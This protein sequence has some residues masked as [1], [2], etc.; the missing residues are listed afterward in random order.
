MDLLV[1]KVLKKVLS[2]YIKSC[3]DLGSGNDIKLGTNSSVQLRN[4]QLKEQVIGKMM[5]LPKAIE[6]ESA[7]CNEMNVTVPLSLMKKPI[8]IEIEGVHASA[9]EVDTENKTK[10]VVIIKSTTKK[11]KRQIIDTILINVNNFIFEYQSKDLKII[12]SFESF[13]SYFADKNFKKISEIGTEVA[14]NNVFTLRRVVEIKNFNM[15]VIK[16]NKEFYLIRNMNIDGKITQIR[17]EDTYQ[18][19]ETNVSLNIN[20][21]R[22]VLLTEEYMITS[23]F[24]SHFI[25]IYTSSLLF[26][27]DGTK[28]K[29]YH[30]G[31]TIIS[32]RLG[33]FEITVKNEG[34]TEILRLV[35]EQFRSNISIE[36]SQNTHCINFSSGVGMVEMIYESNGVGKRVLSAFGDNV[37]NT[38]INVI[39]NEGILNK[40][41][42]KISLDG[43][44]ISF[45]SAVV[46]KLID[47]IKL[48]IIDKLNNSQQEK[49]I[50]QEPESTKNFIEVSKLIV[51][52]LRKHL[53]VIAQKC[54]LNSF[55][56]IV[57]RL[58]MTVQ[59]KN[60]I[61]SIPFEEGGGC[62]MYIEGIEFNNSPKFLNLTM[63][64]YSK[65]VI[66]RDLNYV[67]DG[68]KIKYT[69][70]IDG[71]KIIHVNE[72]GEKNEIVSPI[73][74]IF[75]GV[76]EYEHSPIP[77]M[78]GFEGIIT[79]IQINLNSVI[80]LSL[81]KY[82]TQ[83]FKSINN[84]I[85]E[86]F[87]QIAKEVSSK[88]TSIIDSSISFLNNYLLPLLDKRDVPTLCSS[89]IIK[90]GS[91]ELPFTTILS[92][93]P[94]ESTSEFI[95][96]NLSFVCVGD[97]LQ[98]G[99]CLFM[100]T[101]KSNHVE[102]ILSP[103]SNIITKPLPQDEHSISI[104]TNYDVGC[105]LS[106]PKQ[107]HF[108]ISLYGLE[109]RFDSLFG[110]DIKDWIISFID[111]PEHIKT[112]TKSLLHNYKETRK[113]EK[114]PEI[115]KIKQFIKSIY[116]GFTCSLS[117]SECSFDCEDVQSK[118]SLSS[119]SLLVEQCNDYTQ[120]LSS[121][122]AEIQMKNFMLAEQ[123]EELT[124][125]IAQ[126]SKKK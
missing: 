48:A 2:N 22:L 126:L 79:N 32:I 100:D 3:P 110:I 37:F 12:M 102:K 107:L 74:A 114:K 122:L 87:N 13:C 94:N 88:S 101:C 95:F 112:T 108:K 43:I 117:L 93:T 83:L 26:K 47:F 14:E 40:I 99:F 23:S 29:Q 61:L 84:S 52:L 104:S 59:I 85:G 111:H 42:M 25:S 67:K 7:E 98:R 118:V 9:K 80:Y 75:N 72:K 53:T 62:N 8:I 11:S 119:Q 121:E 46:L 28:Q 120:K 106:K 76:T 18:L 44:E 34:A 123:K 54:G 55:M 51:N 24:I 58:D 116:H 105:L 73:K 5:M 16:N 81:N 63:N 60:C 15:R 113:L 45:E 78:I 65:E 89:I 20:R 91:F 56:D 103:F 71:I 70:G 115:E 30:S 4:V 125:Q 35:T 38:R 64:K 96:K 49:Q 124:R 31:K 50:K 17:D 41:T 109:L 39:I 69:I 90:N 66:Q 1:S 33:T 27:N 97:S 77:L 57:E 21:L 19:I 92:V 10:T 68:R 82:F 6:I 86:Q 36:N